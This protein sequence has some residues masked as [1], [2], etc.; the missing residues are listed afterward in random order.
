MKWLKLKDA[1]DYEFYEDDARIVSVAY[2]DADSIG[3]TFENKTEKPRFRTQIVVS[4]IAAKELAKQLSAI[5][6]RDGKPI[7][8]QV[9][10]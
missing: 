3:I 6:R 1:L 9:K 7:W 2:L 5:L 8:K 4:R 10:P